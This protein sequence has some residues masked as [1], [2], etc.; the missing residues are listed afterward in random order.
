LFEDASI[1]KSFFSNPFADD[2]PSIIFTKGRKEMAI[3]SSMAVLPPPLG[4]T[5]MVSFLSNA[6]SRDEKHLKFIA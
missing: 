5:R 4:A 3:P 1:L 6:T 2:F